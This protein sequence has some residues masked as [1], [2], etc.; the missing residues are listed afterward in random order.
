MNEEMIIEWLLAFAAG[1]DCLEHE[2]PNGT[3]EFAEG[4]QDDQA[5]AAKKRARSLEMEGRKVLAEYG[6]TI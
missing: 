4:L 3:S 5:A 6:G 1:Q 2:Q